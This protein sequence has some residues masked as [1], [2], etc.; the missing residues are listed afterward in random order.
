M[1]LFFCAPAVKRNVIEKNDWTIHHPVSL[2][3]FIGVGCV[4]MGAKIEDVQR[5]ARNMA[6]EDI[7]SQIKVRVE[8]NTVV[9]ETQKTIDGQTTDA[10]IFNEK[11][12]TYTESIL[13]GVE[14]VET[15]IT[16]DG[17]YC[18]KLS[19]NKAAYFSKLNEKSTRPDQSQLM[20]WLLQRRQ[21]L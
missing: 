1:P 20:V 13:E 19:L 21:I 18:I 7:S 9:E 16:P 17:N 8:G 5:A 4:K 10:S 15:K 12:K 6:L 2:T 14:T 11:I 3:H